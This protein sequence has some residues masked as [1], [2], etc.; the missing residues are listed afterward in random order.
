MG[1]M[2][3]A[4]ASLEAPKSLA[5]S[6]FFPWVAFALA[7]FWSLGLVARYGAN[8]P[9]S[10]EWRDFSVILGDEPF[11]LDWVWRPHSVHRIPLPRLIRLALYRWSGRDVRSA[12]FFNVG[13]M[14]IATLFMLR[15]ASR[16]RGGPSGL[17]AFFPLL[18]LGP[19][20]YMNFLWAFQVQFALSSSLFLVAMAMVVSASRPPSQRELGF[21]A[22]SLVL[23]VLTG[24]N[25]LAFAVP[26]IVW[27]GAAV[28]FAGAKSRL[29]QVVSAA[30]V[31]LAVC[32]VLLY[33][34]GLELDS[35]IATTSGGILRTAI[36]FLS[37][38]LVAAVPLWRGRAA[39]VLLLWAA[40]VF[41]LVRAS[42]KLPAEKW[43][44]SGLLAGFL[45]MFLLAA[46]V[47]FGR[48]EFTRDAG[49]QD[50]YATLA[51]PV[52]CLVYLSFLLYGGARTRRAVPIALLA[53]LLLSMPVS[54]IQALLYGELRLAEVSA[55]QRDVDAGLPLEAVAARNANAVFPFAPSVP[56]YLSRLVARRA[57]PFERY[58]VDPRVRTRVLKRSEL[59]LDSAETRDLAS[60][61]GGLRPS[62]PAPRLLVRFSE[63]RS[64]AGLEMR[65]SLTAPR[66]R[67]V[68][69]EI[70]WNLA[71]G[72]MGASHPGA[73][74]ASFPLFAQAGPQ[75]L[76]AFVYDDVD[77]LRI[78]LDGAAPGL[79][80]RK[81]ILMELAPDWL[82]PRAPEDSPRGA[83]AGSLP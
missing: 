78:D 52:L 59:A 65:F 14:A 56:A 13:V 24:A 38:S 41:V 70:H 37:T 26:W 34:V 82:P 4:T 15:A 6:V 68:R 48:A 45:S 75:S 58:E 77:S 51:A 60:Q 46:F 33:P 21:I 31:L 69:T 40:A 66:G 16:C 49:I 2:G 76:T 71:A 57:W 7:L 9:R 28:W 55:L 17:D 81:L 63:K 27:T 11:T 61:E 50:R 10:D 25:G 35:P 79:V 30:L 1:A 64:V 54:L 53:A 39:F 42:R 20:H 67:L 74:A 5:A 32:L 19:A 62:G 3:D 83:F 12:M 43:R 80:I 8:L 73:R 18:L 47:G 72:E 36:Q 22:L 23:Q 29:P 44:A